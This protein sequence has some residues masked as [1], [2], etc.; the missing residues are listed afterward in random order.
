MTAPRRAVRSLGCA[1]AALVCTTVVSGCHF[2][3][4][5]ALPLPF[6]GGTGSGSYTVTAVMGQTGNLPPHAEVMVNNVTVGTVTAIQFADW[7]ARLTISLPRSVKLPA[8]TTATIGQK[9]LLGA[10]YVALAPPAN[11]PPTGRLR[12]GDVIPLSR[13]ST[14]PSTEDVL[15]ALS[16]V[17]NGGGLNQLSTITAELNDT[18]GGHEQQTRELLQNL[19]IFAG[20]LNSQRASIVSTL[21]ALD[22]LSAQLK[23][24]DNT[25]ARAIDDI[26][27]G[28][29]VLNKDEKNLTAALVATSNLGTVA[30]RVINETSQNLLANLR[31]LQPALR[32]LAD[33]GQNL[34]NSIPVLATFPFPGK[35]LTNSLKGDYLNVYLSLD[36][37]LPKLQKAWLTGSPVLGSLPLLGTDKPSTTSSNPLTT[38]LQ[39]PGGTSSGS[40][41]SKTGKT[42]QPGGSSPGN[43]GGLGGVV[44][45]VLGSL[46]GGGNG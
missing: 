45:G 29:A 1:A 6:T 43:G 28:L 16:T 37:T 21:D 36:L 24:G 17:L 8:N 12:G 39:L 18:L 4:L 34:V 25:L 10:E 46:L 14:Y 23:A 38:P 35:A 33:S 30:D 13:T 32:R 7:H 40:A 9:S 19:R 31:D 2:T 22:A 20:T 44:G 41:P 42:S 26:P 27:A 5:G 3:G 15:A 11:A